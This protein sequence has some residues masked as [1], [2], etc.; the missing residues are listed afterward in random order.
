MSFPKYERYKDSGVESLGE[1]PEHWNISRNKHIF[2][3]VNESVGKKSTEFQLLSLTLRGVI[4]RDIDGKGKFP[5]EFDTYQVVKAGNIIFCLFDIDETPRTVGLSYEYGMITGA[6]VVVTALQ[7]ADPRFIYYYYFNID[8][9]KGLRP[10][11]TG[12]RKVV[13]PE[14]FMNIE[15]P[16]PSKAEQTKI[17][18][19]LDRETS[20]IDTLIAEQKRLIALLKEKRQ[21]V[22]SH[23]VT[24]GLDSSVP[25]KNSG[26]EWLG[27]VP[28]HW[29]IVKLARVLQNL[30]QGWSPNASNQPADNG[31]WGV[32]KISAIKKGNFIEHENKALL[33][34]TIPDVS[35][36]VKNGDLLVTRANTPEL[37]GD[38]CIVQVNSG[39]RLMLSDLTYRLILQENID[40]KFI[41]YFLLSTFGRSQIKADARGSSM[42]MAKISQG[43]IKAWA[44][45]LPPHNEQAK[46]DNY[47]SVELEKIDNLVEVSNSTHTLLQERRSA[48]I[49]AAVTGKI[50]LRNWQL[51]PVPETHKQL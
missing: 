19:F 18:D 33:E 40:A 22:I 25:M 36:E 46:I 47:L 50:D 14:T 29:K 48:L 20:R 41:C 35:I 49:S 27:E 39:C 30:E 43:H 24:K 17:T 23:A 37:V 51:T 10:F 28:K 1:V 11:Y 2:R 31:E 3:I 32:I 42:S 5:A 21:A 44:L 7:C 45:P 38:A 16:L 9:R 8:L 4:P 34:E 13:R 26:V 6:Y 15:M 12:L